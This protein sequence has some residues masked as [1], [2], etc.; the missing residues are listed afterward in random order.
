MCRNNRGGSEVLRYISIHTLHQKSSFKA[1]NSH[2]TVRSAHIRQPRLIFDINNSYSTA[3]CLHS[4]T[5]FIQPFNPSHLFDLLPLLLFPPSQSLPILH[6]SHQKTHARSTTSSVNPPH[7]YILFLIH[8]LTSIKELINNVL[9]PRREYMILVGRTP[10]GFCA[11]VVARETQVSGRHILHGP[12]AGPMR[13]DALRS[14]IHDVEGRAA[15]EIAGLMLPP[16][17]EP[18]DEDQDGGGNNGGGINGVSDSSIPTVR[19][20]GSRVR[21]NSH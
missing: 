13:M 15:S 7:A 20:V 2:S 4:P 19:A 18:Q 14:L 11:A 12:H 10:A 21:P 5:A 16:A 9:D 3:R 6:T 8:K 17:P 1:L